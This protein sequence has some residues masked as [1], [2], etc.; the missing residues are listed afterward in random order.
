MMLDMEYG[1][2]KMNDESTEEELEEEPED[3][4][5]YVMWDDEDT[6]EE[7][8]PVTQKDIDELVN[9]IINKE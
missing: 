2:I 9:K 3:F 5:E 4:W 8:K 7:I 1:V 6:V